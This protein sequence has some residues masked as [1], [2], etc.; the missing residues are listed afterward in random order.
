MEGLERLIDT[1]RQSW[2]TR[3]EERRSPVRQSRDRLTF[4]RAL[5]MALP[6]SLKGK[7]WLFLHLQH[8]DEID[9]EE[10]ARPTAGVQMPEAAPDALVGTVRNQ[11]EPS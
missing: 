8:Q 3:V 10:P 11:S 4:L 7:G 9:Q 6:R 1:Y 5:N 2:Q